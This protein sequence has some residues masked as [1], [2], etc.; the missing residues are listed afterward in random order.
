LQKQGGFVPGIRPGKETEM[1]LQR[2][3]NRVNL[4]GASFLGLIAVLPLLLQAVIGSR[5]LT[6]GGTSLLIVVAVAIETYKQIDSQITMH[7]YDHL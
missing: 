3:V 5:S 2:T 6:I 1:Y 7:Q 4:V